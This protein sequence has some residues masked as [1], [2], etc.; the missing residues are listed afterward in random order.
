VFVA[1]LDGEGRPLEELGDAKCG[2]A[3]LVGELG[4]P[5]DRA[6]EREERVATL[7]DRLYRSLCESLRIAH[8][9]GAFAPRP[10]CFISLDVPLS[11]PGSH[12]RARGRLL[13]K[14]ARPGRTPASAC[15]RRSR[16][17]P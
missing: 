2:L 13:R 11:M 14:G 1:A 9:S 17:P 8:A 16:S 12:D 4:F 15:A 7:V 5:V 10:R 6:R 3:L